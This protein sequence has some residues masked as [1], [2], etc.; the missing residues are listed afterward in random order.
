ML[1]AIRF[2]DK[3]GMQ[4]T[5]KALLASHLDWLN[6]HQETILVG[7]SLRISPDQT[8]VGGLWIAQAESKEAL[9]GLIE[10]DPFWIAKLRHSVEILH[11]SKAFED[12]QVLV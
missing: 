2:I 7:G 1:F 8:P 6:Q 12:R 10:S 5:R 11:W 4:E 3:T 9:M